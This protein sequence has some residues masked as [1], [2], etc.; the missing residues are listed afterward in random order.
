MAAYQFTQEP[1]NNYLQISAAPAWETLDKLAQN[2]P[3]F[4]RRR[5]FVTPVA[6][7]QWRKS[8]QAYQIGYAKISVAIANVIGVDLA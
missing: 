6:V 8:R 7:S 3:H 4:R 1:D 2:Q 5:R